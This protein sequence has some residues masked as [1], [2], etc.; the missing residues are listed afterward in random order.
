MDMHH[1][2]AVSLE[3]YIIGTLAFHMMQFIISCMV[4]VEV[5]P[6]GALPLSSGVVSIVFLFID[7]GV[8]LEL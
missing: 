5:S 8:I 7:T 3:L 1:E 4:G 6:I 2:L